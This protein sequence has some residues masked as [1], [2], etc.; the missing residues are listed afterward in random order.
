MGLFKPAW[1]DD[2]GEKAEKAVEK[3][4]DQNTLTRIVKEAP[5][6]AA[7]R[8][9]AKKL[10]NQSF[11]ANIAKN[12][13]DRFVRLAAVVGLTDQNALADIAK[14]SAD[15]LIVNEVITKLTDQTVIADY[16]KNISH[17][18]F[19][20]SYWDSA[21]TKSGEKSCKKLLENISD[22]TLL[23]DIAMNTKN[24]TVM[25]VAIVKITD[26]SV[27]T[28]IIKTT[29]SRSIISA[30]FEKLKN[31]S[32]FAEIAYNADYSLELRKQAL[33]KL[34]DITILS[35]IANT[36]NVTPLSNAAKIRIEYLEFE[37]ICKGNHTWEFTHSKHETRG[38]YR[39]SYDY[40]KCTKCGKTKYEDAGSDKM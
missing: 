34:S 16:V 20:A 29:K 4:T 27:L 19:N 10:T 14:N 31:Q 1:M 17:M 3:V 26:Q 21:A 25:K 12:D 9:A 24:S 8:A 39:D 11:L 32:V 15:D 7:R 6:S 13:E 22:E 5:S 28:K 35:E 18:A 23:T 36:V 2:W 37:N 33:E 30:V 38:D 40:Y